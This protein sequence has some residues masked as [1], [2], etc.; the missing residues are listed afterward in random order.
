M[1]MYCIQ[2]NQ[3]SVGSFF[4][5]GN[6]ITYIG[7]E[8][9]RTFMLD[10]ILLINMGLHNI[11]MGCLE[12]NMNPSLCVQIPTIPLLY[13]NGSQNDCWV[14]SNV[15]DEWEV[16]AQMIVPSLPKSTPIWCQQWYFSYWL[17]AMCD[18][19]T[20]RSTSWSKWKKD[21]RLPKSEFPCTPFAHWF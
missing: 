7:V 17:S 1:T 3:K 9:L 8:T 10:K 14:L 5:E 12:H 6:L 15:L 4:C 13:S 18:N 21:L 20:W 2:M 16:C 11:T 19:G